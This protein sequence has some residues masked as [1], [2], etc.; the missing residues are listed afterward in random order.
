ML[1][2]RA[3]AQSRHITDEDARQVLASQ[4]QRYR[5]DLVAGSQYETLYEKWDLYIPFLE[6]SHSMLR[7]SGEMIF[8]VS[9]AYDSSKYA[10]K[11]HM[12]FGKRST[13]ERIDF[14]TDIPIFNAGVKNT[15]LHISKSE[16]T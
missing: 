10:S 12:Y 14:C 16:T 1:Y 9:N 3:D 7:T 6:R 2:V 4:W 5:R 15:I 11:S 8:I 13:I